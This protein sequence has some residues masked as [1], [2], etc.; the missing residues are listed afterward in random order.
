MTVWEIYQFIEFR[1]NK[2]QSG[3]SYTPEQF[4]LACKAVNIEYFKLK[5]GLPEEYRVGAPMPRQAWQL[6]QKITDDLR[7]FMHV[8]GIDGP[9][10]QINRFGLA[11][12]PAN[13]VRESSIMYDNGQTVGC[14]TE[15]GWVPVE[16]VTDAVWADRIGSSLKYPDKENPFCRFIG[17]RVEFRPKIPSVNMT[18]LRMPN[19][20]I[21]GYTI[22]SNN[23]IVYN[24]ATSTQF[25]WPEDTHTDIANNLYSW[26]GENL[27][28]PLM[29]QQA[30]RRKMQ[31]Q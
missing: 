14:T 22:D 5:A 12:L 10:L 1:A 24:P 20:A 13:Y 19:P 25:E 2:D 31:G 17:S 23:D 29:I 7:M 21:L 26:L 27:N 3:R 6:T 9:Q 18:Y 15:E 8:M 30:E 4:N 28:S 16:V 11:T